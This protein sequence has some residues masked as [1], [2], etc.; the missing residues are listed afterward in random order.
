MIQLLLREVSPGIDNPA[1]RSVSSLSERAEKCFRRQIVLLLNH[2]PVLAALFIE[3]Q[4]SAP[5]GRQ[6][7]GFSLPSIHADNRIAEALPRMLGKFDPTGAKV[8]DH[9]RRDG[10][11]R[12][13]TVEEECVD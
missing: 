3:V 9:R 10:S 4:N 11:D 5:H 13:V 7:Q 12:A 2:G 8:V 6:L 1:C